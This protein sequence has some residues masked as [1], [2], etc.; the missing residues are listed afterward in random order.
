[1][2]TGDHACMMSILA[3]TKLS[4]FF[5]YIYLDALLHAFIFLYRYIHVSTQTEKHI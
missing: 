1:M 5:M 4:N 3:W 2:P